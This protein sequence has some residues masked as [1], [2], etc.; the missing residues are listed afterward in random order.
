MVFLFQNSFGRGRHGGKVESDVVGAGD[1]EGE[2]A[3]VFYDIVHFAAE[4][5][6]PG[7]VGAEL[8]F[9]GGHL[10]TVDG[11]HN[12]VAVG[13]HGGGFVFH[14]PVVEGTHDADAAEFGSAPFQV[15]QVGFHIVGGA[16]GN[17]H[18]SGV[19]G[20]GEAFHCAGGHTVLGCGFGIT[21]YAVEH[22]GVE[23]GLAEELEAFGTAHH[24]AVVH[25]VGSV[26]AKH[27]VN[28][29][30]VAGGLD[31][32]VF[33]GEAYFVG[34]LVHVHGNLVF[35][36]I[37]NHTG[38]HLGF[39]RLDQATAFAVGGY[40]TEGAFPVAGLVGAFGNDFHDRPP[41]AAMSAVTSTKVW[42]SGWS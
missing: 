6:C 28:G 36:G 29:L 17:F 35:A 19:L 5:D 7:M 13:S 3:A 37:G 33:V 1:I 32:E 31:P 10:Y 24:A 9:A 12:A 38:I 30:V 4:A 22:A 34:V 40:D 16:C 2:V 20:F 42:K 26:Q 21:G 8:E 11:V 27:L 14:I 23:V 25:I 41:L 15:L 18:V 39:G